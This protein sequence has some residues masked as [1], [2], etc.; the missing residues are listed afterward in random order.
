MRPK[1][2]VNKVYIEKLFNHECYK[3]IV[4]CLCVSRVSLLKEEESLAVG[5]K[6]IKYFCSY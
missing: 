3:Y 4:Q 5:A 1:R 2:L 6:K